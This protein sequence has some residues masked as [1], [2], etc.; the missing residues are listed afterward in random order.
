MF[1]YNLRVDIK[2][3]FSTV[4][5]NSSNHDQIICISISYQNLQIVQIG[6]A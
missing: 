5:R 1:Q 6:V 3:D 4:W 2:I